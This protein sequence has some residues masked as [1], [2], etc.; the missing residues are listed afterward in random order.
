MKNEN[1][2]LVF[3]R[4]LLGNVESYTDVTHKIPSRVYFN[5]PLPNFD[6]TDQKNALA[7]L[8]KNRIISNFK[9]DDGDFVITKPSQSML[10]DYYFKLK[11]KPASKPEMPVDTELRFDEKTGM[12]SMGGK[13]CNIPI[14]THEYFVCKAV[15]AVPFGT[16]VKE[17]D[18]LDYMDWAKD[19]KDSVYDAMRAVNKKVKEKLGIEKLMRWKVRRIIIDQKTG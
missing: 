16:P 15:F 3:L 1:A 19:H 7:E 8:K 11:N 18:I 9:L 4:V 14:N 12:I 17:I 6:I 13:L 2:K 10:N 5:C